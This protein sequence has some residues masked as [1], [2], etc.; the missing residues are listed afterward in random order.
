VTARK[1]A[2]SIGQ[3]AILLVDPSAAENP[4]YRLAPSV[5]HYPSP[6]RR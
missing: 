3:G 5:L 2:P 1:A 4:F 6:R